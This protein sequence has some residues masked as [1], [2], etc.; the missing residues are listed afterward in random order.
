[1]ALNRASGKNWV[2]KLVVLTLQWRT[3]PSARL[4]RFPVA[5]AAALALSPGLV[6]VA[7]A[8]P[9]DVEQ[10]ALELINRARF[11]PEREAWRLRSQFWGDTGTPHLPDI[12]EG[13]PSF[14][15]FPDTKP[16]LAFNGN[17]IQS[18]RDYSNT[19]LL[20]NAFTSTF[21]GTSPT[22]RAS[23]NG[24]TAASLAENLGLAT[25]NGA[26]PISQAIADLNHVQ[27]FVD[28]N[29]TGRTNRINLMTLAAKEVGIGFGQRN[30][31]VTPGQNAVLSVYDIG[32]TA[33]GGAILTGV[34][35]S[36]AT[37]NDFY[38]VGEGLA[39][40]TVSATPSPGGSGGTAASTTTFSSGGYSLALV[41]G[42]YNIT[43]S[44]AGLSAPITY[45]KV[46]VS[47]TNVKLDVASD[48]GMWDASGGGDWGN[49][50]NWAGP[51]PVG[52]GKT[53]V[54]GGKPQNFPTINLTTDTTVGQIIF[55][56]TLDHTIASSNG[57]RLIFETAGS[58][59]ARIDY[60]GN[61]TISAPIQLNRDL[62]IGSGAFENLT[63]S[64]N[65]AGA[66]RS[67]LKAG[68]GQLFLSGDNT[69]SG[70]F[71]ALQGVVFPRHSHAFGTGPVS[72]GFGTSFAE[73]TFDT[74][75][76]NIANPISIPASG[77][78][79][80]NVTHPPGT[81]T[82]SGGLAFYTGS[83]IFVAGSNTLNI[84]GPI[85]EVPGST[86]GGFQ[87]NGPGTM[88]IN[89]VN[90]F[91]SLAAVTEGTLILNGTIPD[92]QAL[93]LS[94]GLTRLGVDQ[95]L[96]GLTI[97]KPDA[98]LDLNGHAIRLFNLPAS[99]ILPFLRD[100]MLTPTSPGGIFDSTGNGRT[101]IGF[102][103]QDTTHALV[104]QTLAG[105]ATL[106]LKVDFAD[107]VK[108]AQNYDTVGGMV[109]S[110]GDFNYDG[111]VDFLDLVKLA[112]NYNGALAGGAVPGAPAGFDADLA[113]ALT[114]AP[115][116]GTLAGPI[117][118]GLTLAIRRRRR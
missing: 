69:F 59:A 75:G 92:S 39:G 85:T 43:F 6:A 48:H 114:S 70:G 98:S 107:L 47:T 88:I 102:V 33:S 112:Q 5:G 105:D 99:Q 61:H 72:I 7:A 23:A 115:E 28:A 26:L 53:A 34:A 13:L 29:H 77:D 76:L 45:N 109:W 25:S 94:G 14:S 89:G 31:Y 22:S 83:R 117:A 37:N 113:R 116:P 54:F 63:L 15:I 62:E 73:L 9:T 3:M 84:T 64:G 108:V 42:T 10:Y 36:D 21:G 12:A 90:T 106:D 80:I 58:N 68:R 20:N 35:F 111:N 44:G 87:K 86:G 56:Q 93:F 79:R 100:S 52:A 19:L 50:A 57:A 11:D 101:A 38:D 49:P 95:E 67:I 16:P 97:F 71:N 4:S 103:V 81:T 27:T 91:K 118:C 60:H 1:M 2:D 40:I 30:G 82:L 78:N 65:I 24:Y 66:G 55:V 18:A 32:A 46:A 41:P 8:P 104:K 17:L 96:K 74:P 110:D 51:V